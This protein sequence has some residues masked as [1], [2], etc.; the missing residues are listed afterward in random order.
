MQIDS[1]TKPPQLPTFEDVIR[2]L[3]QAAF[4]R[5]IRTW[6]QQ[7]D[8]IRDEEAMAEYRRRIDEWTAIRGAKA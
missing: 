2:A 8:Q 6:E 5:F 4:D 7:A 1:T 3:P